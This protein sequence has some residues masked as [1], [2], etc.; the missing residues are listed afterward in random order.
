MGQCN[1]IPMHGRQTGLQEVLAAAVCMCMHLLSHCNACHRGAQAIYLLL[2]QHVPHCDF[3]LL[4]LLKLAWC[5]LPCS[6]QN[7]TCF[8]ASHML[9]SV[10]IEG[11]F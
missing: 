9:I 11:F 5:M 10:V 4:P 1:Y 3:L 6:A 7:A 8:A 2:Q